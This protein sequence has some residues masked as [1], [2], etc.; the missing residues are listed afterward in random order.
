MADA[1]AAQ[2]FYVDRTGQEFGPFRT[3]KMKSWFSQGF[4]PIGEDLLVRLSDWATES[5]VPVKLLYPE[6]SIFVGAPSV[7][8]GMGKAHGSRH[9]LE[10]E[11][12]GPAPP[13]P[14]SRSP[15]RRPEDHALVP[16][17]HPP[18][19][20][21]PPPGA[22]GGYPPP[23]AY[24]HPPPYGHPPAYGYPPPGYPPPYGYP[25]PGYPPPPGY[26][27]Y[28]PPPHGYPPPPGYGPRSASSS[29]G[30]LGRQ[31]GRLK[32]FNPKHGFGFIDCPEARHRYGRDVFVHKAQ[33]G[34]LDIGEDINFNVDTNKDGMP[35]AR[36]IRRMDGRKPGPP[37][38]G[39]EKREAGDS[40]APDGAKKPRRR[41]GKAKKKANEGEAGAPAP[42]GKVAKAASS[43]EAAKAA[44]TSESAGGAAQAE[45]PVAAEAETPAAAQ[46]EAPASDNESAPAEADPEA[47][48]PEAASPPAEETGEAAAAKTAATAAG[49]EE[50]PAESTTEPAMEAAG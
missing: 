20:Y 47:A 46:A 21:A 31:T 16:S 1:G 25:P 49:T 37:R 4:F 45:T 44:A 12:P 48:S 26:G 19:A 50:K 33:I 3:T 32:S 43:D 28:G 14:R 24:G 2:W 35:Q 6:G 9:P 8:P 38:D 39:G 29:S 34:D 17:S 11:Q 15:R 30:L 22:Y 23:P 42:A 18:P 7:R 36:D 10:R 27:P 40:S 5:H 13:R 41:G